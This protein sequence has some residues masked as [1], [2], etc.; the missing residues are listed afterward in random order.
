M[1]FFYQTVLQLCCII[2]F[3]Q[4]AAAT[5]ADSVLNAVTKKLNSLQTLQYTITR[6]MNYPAENYHQV[7]HWKS[8]YDFTKKDNAPGCIY[9]VEN[10][11][12]KF[13]FNGAEK[14]D[15]D[16]KNKTAAIIRRP[17]TAVFDGAS[18]FYN[19]VIT[20]KNALPRL[21]AVTTATTIISDTAINGAN[22][23]LVR[24]NTGKHRM[25][26]LG[27]DFDTMQ[28]T[29]DFIYTFI[30]H[31]GSYLPYEIVQQFETSFIKTTFTDYNLSPAAPEELSWY[32]S[33]YTG[34]YKEAIKKQ[35]PQLMAAGSKA[36]SWRLKE[37]TT[38][39]TV[40]LNDMK[41]RVV[42]ADFW[43]KNCGACIKSVPFLKSLQSR[44][45]N[46]PF[47]L[48]SINAY[49]AAKEIAFFCAKNKVSYSVLSGGMS[50]A[51][52]YG[53]SGYPAFF[54]IDKNG[55]VLYSAAGYDESMHLA[56]EKVITNALK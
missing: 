33:S 23:M 36:P 30:I 13:I 32:Y 6:E 8:Y 3:Q 14:F 20:L 18:F 51:E 35:N 40:S 24:V 38:G 28:T 29:Y 1:N 9:Q 15:L 49:D 5:P 34:I 37:Y 2:P 11:G 31:P 21:A 17:D 16:K 48:V 43:I 27:L 26:N 12:W 52:Q 56:I 39:K 7:I 50:A 22:Y 54:I 19:S 55:T 47:S 42:L 46:T 10:D 44:F 53:V 25:Q 41:G 4:T 45:K